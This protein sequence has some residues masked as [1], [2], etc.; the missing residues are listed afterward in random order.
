MNSFSVSIITCTY[1]PSSEVFSKVLNA[2]TQL[3]SKNLEFEYIIVDNNSQPAVTNQTF[4]RDFLT[5]N[6]WAKIVVEKKPG[7]NEA[8]ICGFNHSRY[9]VIL[10]VDDDVELEPEYLDGLLKL[11]TLYPG[12]GAW[13]AGIISVGYMINPGKWFSTKGKLFFQES[14]IKNTIYGND[15]EPT[16]YW[17]FGTGLIIRREIFEEYKKRVNNKIYSLSGRLGAKMA[18]CEDSQMVHCALSMNYS[19]GRSGLLKLTHLTPAS[20]MSIKYLMKLN[21]GLAYSFQYFKKETIPWNY[22]VMSSKAFLKIFVYNTI[23][24]IPSFDFESYKINMMWSAGSYF[25][26]S[27]IKDKKPPVWFRIFLVLFKVDYSSY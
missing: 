19:V 13:N 10:F 26:D 6:K 3:D 8:R 20:K 12:W 16:N 9:N 23:H 15:K 25:A 21:F 18:S 7:L 1:N 4:V 2:I 17:P 27:K 14:N 5:L 24:L 22:N 11:N